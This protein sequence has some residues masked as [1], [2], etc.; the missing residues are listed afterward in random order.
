MEAGFDTFSF[1]PYSSRENFSQFYPSIPLHKDDIKPTAPQTP[2]RQNIHRVP[3]AFASPSVNPDPTNNMETED[4]IA[5]LREQIRQL[6]LQQQQAAA[7]QTQQQNTANPSTV[8]PVTAQALSQMTKFLKQSQ[9]MNQQLL[10]QLSSKPSDP[11]KE[12]PMPTSTREQYRPVLW[13]SLMLQLHK[14]DD[15]NKVLIPTYKDSPEMIFPRVFY[16]PPCS[17]GYSDVPAR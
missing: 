13:S 7:F 1:C 16:L 3:P 12:P 11:V 9:L 17:L 4:D 10:S 8:D 15:I 14:I 5:A 2:P 6:Q